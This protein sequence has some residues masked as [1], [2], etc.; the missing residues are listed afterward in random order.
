MW[1]TARQARRCQL[2]SS[3]CCWWQDHEKEIKTDEVAVET[4]EPEIIEKPIEQEEQV[5]QN[6]DSNSE[7]VE[8]E[9]E[10]PTPTEN[11][12]DESEEE[13]T[14]ENSE[15]LEDAIKQ[16]AELKDEISKLTALNDEFKTTFKT[17][18]DE[19]YST[20]QTFIKAHNDSV[21]NL[22]EVN[23]ALGKIRISKGLLHIRQNDKVAET[24]LSGLIKSMK[25]LA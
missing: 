8:Q 20:M 5:A 2:L 25:D 18:K 15:K 9:A 12:G 1:W 10:T 7:E 11:V 13:N 23:S 14:D 17:F 16:I 21:E 3:W 4:P 6:T 19:V 22:Q 24:P